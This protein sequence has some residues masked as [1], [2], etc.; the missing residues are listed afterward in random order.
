MAGKG[1]LKLNKAKTISI[2]IVAIMIVV[3]LFFA[4]GSTTNQPTTIQSTTIALQSTTSSV[5]TA[6]TTPTTTTLPQ[7]NAVVAYVYPYAYPNSTVNST[8]NTTAGSTF[9]AQLSSNAGST[10]YDWKVSTSTGITYLNYTVVSTSNLPGGPQVRD[11]YFRALQAGSQTI[12]LKD[13]R[14]WEPNVIAAIINL[15]VNVS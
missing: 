14:P 6:S 15:D 13:E 10:G 1:T 11:Y 3:A 8:I 7:A 9:I 2:L 5:T 12:T 4:L